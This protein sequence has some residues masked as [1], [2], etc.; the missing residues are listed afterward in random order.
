MKRYLAYLFQIATNRPIATVLV[1]IILTFSLFL[2]LGWSSWNAYQ[3]F[4]QIIIYDFR[5]QNLAGSIIHLD[6]VLTMSARMN[7]ATGDTRWEKRYFQFEPQLSAAIE[8]AIQ[9]APEAYEGEG[10]KQT[11]AANQK[12]IAMEERSFELVR[13]GQVEAATEILFS[14]EYEKQKTIYAEGIQ[15][16]FEATATRIRKNLNNFAQQLILA[17]AIALVSLLLLLPVWWVVLQVL[18]RYLQARDIAE[19]ALEIKVLQRTSDLAR[20]S[21]E[22]QIL[23]QKLES[24]NLRMS[25]ELDI[26]RQM[27]QLILPKSDELKIEGLDIAGFMEP[28]DEVGGDYYDVLETDGVV[29]I[30]MGDVTGHG[31]ESGIL[32]L[33]TQTAV[34]VLKEIR[35]YDPVRFLDALNRTIYKNLQRMNSDRNLTLVVL[36]YADSQVSISGQHEETIV[37]RRDGYIERISTMDLGF[38]IG[39][40]DNIIE[41]IN[42]TTVTLQPGDGIVLYTDGVTEARDLAKAQY[43]VERLCKKIVQHW[44]RSADEIK[45]AVIEDVRQHI[46]SQRVF[47]DITL[48]V[49][50]QKSATSSK[51]K[52]NA[53]TYPMHESTSS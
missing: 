36:N 6:E 24:E 49:L 26:L 28:A 25:A 42:H 44:H 1:A 43:G 30:G 34:R 16:G 27:Q 8:E 37:V 18:R 11:D 10:A 39:L 46:G 15:R 32:M 50:K 3:T 45:Q 48:L 29:T 35:E 23:N 31:L 7:A 4:N 21:E 51:P 22:I 53:H 12:L 9:I 41:F 40:D 20:A 52:E 19:R 38:P 17:S 47:D 5:L 13:N 33:M 2:P 14:Q